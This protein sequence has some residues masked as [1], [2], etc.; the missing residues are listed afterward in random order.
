MLG[1]DIVD[2]EQI[3]VVYDKHGRH[4]LDKILT[5]RE[6]N[7]LLKCSPKIFFHRLAYYFAA[8]EAVFK[9]CGDSHLGWKDIIIRRMN[10][11]PEVEIQ[12]SDFRSKISL[13]FSATRDIV[14]AQAVVSHPH[15]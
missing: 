1:I 4:F 10:P 12:R 8:K 6:I 5:P 7:D 11:H 14:I 3:K 13:T 9:A 15:P 2:I